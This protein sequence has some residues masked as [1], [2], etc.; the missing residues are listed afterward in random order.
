MIRV[1]LKVLFIFGDDGGE[2]ESAHS[3]FMLIEAY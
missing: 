1:S 2:K 3:F